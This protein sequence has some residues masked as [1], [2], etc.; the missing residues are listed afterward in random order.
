MSRIVDI[1]FSIFLVYIAPIV[2]GVGLSS[3]SSSDFL[4]KIA[5]I[6]LLVAAIFIFGIACMGLTRMSLYFHG[7]R[8]KEDGRN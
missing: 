2:A 4:G 7:K 8:A 6:G 5:S 3:F 1:I